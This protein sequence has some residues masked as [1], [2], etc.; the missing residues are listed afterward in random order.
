[1]KVSWTD[2]RMAVLLCA[3][4]T[5]VSL[6]STVRASTTPQTTWTL[7]NV[8]KQL[9]TQAASFQSLTAD[10]ER[11]RVRVAVYDAGR[12]LL[13]CAHAV[14]DQL[15]VDTWMVIGALSHELLDLDTQPRGERRNE[16]AGLLVRDE[17]AVAVPVG[18]DD[19]QPRRHR[20]GDGDPDRHLHN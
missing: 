15:S 10:L 7:E 17:I 9:D 11:P 1:M 8:L 18:R 5:A 6:F 19:R 14:R 3:L 20:F 4:M 13:D 12:H 16:K 2:R